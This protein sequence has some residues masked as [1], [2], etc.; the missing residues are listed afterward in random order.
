MALSDGPRERHREIAGVFTDRV[1]G[2]RDWDAPAPVA[3]WT[4]RDVVRHLVE[5]FPGFLAAGT[6]IELPPGP[7]VDDDPVGAWQA[8]CDAV[9]AVLDDPETAD[10]SLSNPH[11]GEVPLDRGDRPGSTPPTCSCT[12]GTW[13]A[14]PART[15]GST[16]SSAPRCWPGWS[17]WRRSCAPPASTARGSPVPDDADAQTRMLGFIGRDPDWTPAAPRRRPAPDR[18]SR[19]RKDAAV[20]PELPEVESARASSPGPRSAGASPTSTTPTRSSAARTRP[21]R[22]APP[23]WAVI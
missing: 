7:S 2:A 16:P 12:P 4:A 23:S 1:R 21:A 17:R 13:P 3:G 20:M 8:Q 6:G 22:S 14:P 5:W 18:R 15:T 9:Q 19:V 10:R 11:I